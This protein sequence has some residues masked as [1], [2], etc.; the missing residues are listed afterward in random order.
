M[1]GTVHE[2]VLHVEQVMCAHGEG[3]ETALVCPLGNWVPVLVRLS[4]EWMTSSKLHPSLDL[5]FPINKMLALL[6]STS[7]IQW[8]NISDWG[9]Y[10]QMHYRAFYYK[11][12]NYMLEG[13]KN[14]GEVRGHYPRCQ[15]QL[16]T[17]TPFMKEMDTFFGSKTKRI[18]WT[19]P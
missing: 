4:T 9:A 17:F 16:G 1:L 11:L 8:L 13:R 12:P 18:H 6:L 19:S 7:E 10:Q 2:F 3:L 14:P 15:A 5:S